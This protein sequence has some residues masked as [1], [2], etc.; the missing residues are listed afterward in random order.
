MKIVITCN[1]YLPVMG[2]TIQYIVMLAPEF[3]RQG[4]EV[5]V[6]TRTRETHPTDSEV[7]FEVIRGPSRKKISELADWGD[8]VL[9]VEVSLTTMLPFL[10]KGKA[11]VPTLH[12][13]YPL[14]GLKG[15]AKLMRWLQ[16]CSLRLG[17]PIGVSKWVLDSWGGYGISI[18]NP[19]DSTIF[20]LPPENSPR[21]VDVLYVGRMN[22]AK[23]VYLLI[24]ALVQLAAEGLVRRAVF[25]GEGTAIPDLTARISEAGLTE[26]I[27]LAG[28][29]DT[30]GVASW[31]QRSRVLAFP[32]TPAWLEASPL[33]L[34]EALSCG[35]EVVASDIGGVA[36][37]GGGFIRLVKSGDPDDL[38]KGLRKTLMG[39]CVRRAGIEDYL[40]PQSIPEVTARY[41]KVMKSIT[42]R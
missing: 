37:T 19:V 24:E 3:I 22:H 16:R 17:H 20:K 21:D 14:A 15:K 13:G 23:G 11:Y 42:K 12:A 34:L 33:T 38:L 25:V 35:C 8:V 6:V 1:H 2:G 4:H 30:K 31:M 29:A 10:L 26:A 18:L 39:D 27:Q 28:R 7:P 5:K 9:Q 40:G 32:T 41:I 36:E